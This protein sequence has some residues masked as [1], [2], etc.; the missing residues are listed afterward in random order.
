M[1]HQDCGQTFADFRTNF[2]Y[3]YDEFKIPMTLK[4]HV[5]YDHYEYFL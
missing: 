5:I 4:I 2:M 1:I 3:L